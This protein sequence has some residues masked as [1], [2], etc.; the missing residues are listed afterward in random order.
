MYAASLSSLQHS[1]T[2]ASIKL[3]ATVDAGKGFFCVEINPATADIVVISIF[4]GNA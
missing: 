3:T 2:N 4:V 1:I